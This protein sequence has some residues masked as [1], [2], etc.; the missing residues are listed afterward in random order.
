MLASSVTTVRQ[1]PT[2]KE[3]STSVWCFARWFLSSLLFDGC[4]HF[5]IFFG[6]PTFSRVLALLV[7]MSFFEEFRKADEETALDRIEVSFLPWCLSSVLEE[8]I[9][10]QQTRFDHGETRLHDTTW[11][12]GWL[13]FRQER[14]SKG[15]WRK[16]E[17]KECLRLSF[18]LYM[19]QMEVFGTRTFSS[20]VPR[21]AV[22]CL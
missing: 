2:S 7:L 15:K 8:C 5:H 14:E 9:Y 6:L 4:L 21:S 16:T 19:I 12:D 10:T 20:P 13:Q 18:S 22:L 11:A 17:Y 1:N 3:K